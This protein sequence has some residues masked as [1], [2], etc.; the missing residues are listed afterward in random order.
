MG[1]K[2]QR[3]L[4]AVKSVCKD[5]RN[6]YQGISAEEKEEIVTLV[7]TAKDTDGLTT[8]FPD[9]IGNN[10]WIEH[11]EVTCS[12]RTRKGYENKIQ[13][14][15]IN[16]AVEQRIDKAKEK[17]ETDF[18]F[19]ACYTSTNNSLKNYI[20][21]LEECW[22]KHLDSLKKENER[23]RSLHISAILIE[24]DD[25]L[26]KVA[27][28][29]NMQ[30]GIIKSENTDLPFELIYNKNILDFIYQYKGIIKYVIFKNNY[31]VRVLKVDSIPTIIDLT[32]WS[33]LY[34]YSVPGIVKRSVCCISLMDC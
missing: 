34:V 11:F 7:E 24:S 15:K 3:C 14:S 20:E 19:S 17:E 31:C 29:E 8:K 28:F 22:K 2:E 9:F 25:D 27:K 4:E 26:L 5:D 33:K 23:L 21:S 12:N 18:S 30:Q 16:K 6:Y 13:E 1:K 32:D 10:G